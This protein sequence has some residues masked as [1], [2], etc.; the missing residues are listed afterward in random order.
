LFNKH[1]AI[2]IEEDDK[3]DEAA[4]KKLIKAAVRINQKRISK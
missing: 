1:S 2:V 3:I 4:F